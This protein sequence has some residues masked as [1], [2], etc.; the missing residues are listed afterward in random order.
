MALIWATYKDAGGIWHSDRFRPLC[1]TITNLTLNLIMV[2]FIGLYGILLSTV[3]SYVAVGMPWLLHNIF[4]NLF[5]TTIGSYLKK[6]FYYIVVCGVATFFC[7]Y[8]SNLLPFEGMLNLILRVIL[9]TIM[10]NIIY[11]LAFRHLSEFNESKLMAINML[12]KI[13]KK[14]QAKSSK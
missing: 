9:V 10:A 3:I 13:R 6:L 5:K 7:D 11:F 1:V 2:Q 4:N 14:F 8:F 12:K